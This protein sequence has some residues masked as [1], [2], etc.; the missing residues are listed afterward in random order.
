MRIGDNM[1]EIKCQFLI[2]NVKHKV[3]LMGRTTRDVSIPHR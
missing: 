1:K 2:G 3:M